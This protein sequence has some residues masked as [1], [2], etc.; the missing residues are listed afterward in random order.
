[1]H[2]DKVQLLDVVIKLENLKKQLSNVVASH[3]G[4][5]GHYMVEINHFL[6]ILAYKFLLGLKKVKLNLL[7]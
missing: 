5:E 2:D 4:R 6:N 3:Y 1:M 7:N